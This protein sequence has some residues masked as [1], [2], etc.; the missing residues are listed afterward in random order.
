MSEPP[1]PL[2]LDIYGYRVTVR[3]GVCSVLDNLAQDFAFFRTEGPLSNSNEIELLQ[4]EPPYNEAPY[5]KAVVYT[6]RNVSY[7][8]GSTTLIDYS[9][10]ALGIHDASR[11]SFRLF[12]LDLELL[13]EAAYLF[14]LSQCGEGL[15]ARRL[16]RVH[17]LG[18]CVN[19]CAALV[20]LPM[21]GGKSTL[22]AGLLRHSEIALLSD[23]S[24]LIDSKGDV[25][26]FPLRLGLMPGSEGEI[27]PDHLRKIN[28]ME[29]G[30]KFLVNYVYFADR[31]RS[32]AQ[33][34]LLF[35]GERS[36][37]ATCSVRPAKTTAALRAMLANCVV[38]L[39]LFQ[40]M[41]FIFHRGPG[42]V[43]RK[44]GVA[45]ARLRASWR[46]LRRS[47]KY[48]LVLGRDPA[49]NAQM[50]FDVLAGAA[51]SVRLKKT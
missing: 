31:V 29:F 21:G 45:W 42:E 18:V 23:D 8:N 6:P 14:V 38:G 19:D 28:R 33:P 17:A 5:A 2:S 34:C 27:P 11:G 50:V 15:D 13:Y 48:H 47:T 32:R 43:F 51:D 49:A 22:A 12:S 37:A 44:A 24:P 4:E 20:L 26:A 39:G 16:H 40:G 25:H 41:E 30:P 10:R 7:R 9:G 35:L 36:L 46:L 1:S 3:S